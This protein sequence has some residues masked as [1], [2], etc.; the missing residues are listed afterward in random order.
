MSTPVSDLKAA[1]IGGGNSSGAVQLEFTTP[2]GARSLV[3]KAPN[4]GGL[5]FDCDATREAAILK[6][7]HLAGAPVPRV[8]VIETTG[9]VVGTASF[10]MELVEGRGVPES[11][12]ASFH[13][14]GWFR[15]ESDDVQ[16]GIWFSFLDTLVKLHAIDTSDIPA[17]YSVDGV[18]G[19]LDYWRR[20]L[21]DAAAESHVPRQLA[22][23]DWLGANIPPGADDTPALCMGDARLGNAILQGNDVRALVDF[24]VAYIGNPAADIGYC[25]M[26]EAFTRMLSQQPATGIPTVEETW[27]Y[28]EAATGRTV[29]DRSYW[30]ALGAT[31]MCVTATRA[32]LKW[33]FPLE[34]IDNDNIVVAELEGLV[35]GATA[36][37]R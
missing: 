1:R 28:W 7:A 31:L 4:D 9:E 14:D 32:M 22:I 18:A 21:L 27:D 25:V 15:E 36:A 23:I 16:R 3:L 26:H 11:T 10:A 2:Q 13:D 30:T 17:H 12:P 8:V 6:A 34:T 37:K 33:G 19:Y 20:S 24:E 35:A 29:F 5:V